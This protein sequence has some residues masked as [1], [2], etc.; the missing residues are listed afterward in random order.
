M[1]INNYDELLDKAYEK[2][3]ENVRKLSRFEIPKVELRIESRNTFI[4][5]FNKIISTLNRNR[6]HF[7]GI[8]L[9]KAGTMGEI[10]GQQLF[11]KGQYKD[12]VLN[13][14]IEN[15]TRSYVLCSI[16]NKPDTQIQR[17]G[18]KLFLKCTACGAREEI[19]EK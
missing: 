12:Q 17:E 4:T 5:N 9:K 19:K 2:I 15:Y 1:D 8:F 18:K 3:P 6:K 10:R 11:L 13:R 14:L 16:C 7:L